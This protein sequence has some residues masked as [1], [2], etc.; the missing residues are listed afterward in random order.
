MDQKQMN[1]ARVQA[2]MALANYKD[3]K[4]RRD[5]AEAEMKAAEA[6][7]KAYGRDHVT[8][9]TDNL[10]TLENG[11]IGIKAGP[12]K[13]VTLD[14]KA[15]PTATR[16]ELA[17]KLPAEYVK[18]TLDAAALFASDD[19]KVRQILNAAGVRIVKEDQFTIF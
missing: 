7:I 1:A 5:Q 2:E 18:I 9:F 6:K 17:A 3:A 11:A 8:E 14:G 10:L 15:L 4:R 12:A 19:K 16:A 13:P